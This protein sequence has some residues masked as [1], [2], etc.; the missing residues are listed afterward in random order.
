MSCPTGNLGP[1]QHTPVT[2]ALPKREGQEQKGRLFNLQARMVPQARAI[3][4]GRSLRKFRSSA[5]AAGV[6]IA[7]RAGLKRKRG[8]ESPV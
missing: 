3:A 7:R 5:L 1:A 6:I 2:K 8:N 4:G